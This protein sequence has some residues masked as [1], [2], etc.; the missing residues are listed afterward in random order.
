M[1]RSE[2]RRLLA[3]TWRRCATPRARDLALYTFFPFFQRLFRASGFTTEADQ[4]EQGVGAASLSN[5]LLDAICLIGP[6]ARC[7]QRLGDWRAAGVNLPILVAPIGVESAR[8]VIGAFSRDAISAMKQPVTSEM[9]TGA[10]RLVTVWAVPPHGVR[11]PGCWRR[12]AYPRF[13]VGDS[14]CALESACTTL[15]VGTSQYPLVDRAVRFCCHRAERRFR[16]RW[17]GPGR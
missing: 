10:K 13:R 3:T 7:Q 6:L 16:N 2:F 12:S 17:A 8:G 11:R 1:S 9:S 15:A 5:D 4:M 14:S